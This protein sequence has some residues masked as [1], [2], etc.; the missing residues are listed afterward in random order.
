MNWL[1]IKKKLLK[2]KDSHVDNLMF[3]FDNLNCKV[4]VTVALVKFV[5]G[6]WNLMICFTVAI[7]YI[8]I[9]DVLPILIKFSVQLNIKHIKVG[10]FFINAPSNLVCRLMVFE[11]V[12]CERKKKTMPEFSYCI[13]LTS[14][15]HVRQCYITKHTLDLSGKIILKKKICLKIIDVSNDNSR[16]FS[17]Y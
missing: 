3:I 6:H 16:S 14:Y 9:A 10:A 7:I 13:P 5:G 1:K 11:I 15:I 17:S 4:D 12:Q 2:N 8:H